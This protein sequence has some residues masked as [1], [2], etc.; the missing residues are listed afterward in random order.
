MSRRLALLIGTNNYE[1]FSL[2]A[3]GKPVSDVNGLAEVLADPNIGCF[4]VESLLLNEDHSQVRT[5]VERFFKSKRSDDLLLLYFAGHGVLDEQGRL[6]LA[7]TN[8]QRSLLK[9]T[10]IPA[11]FVAGE[12]QESDSKS[13]LLILDCCHSGAF[14]RGARVAVGAPVHTA[15][16]FGNTKKGFG[17]IV[18][19]ATDATQYAL[20]SSAP[21][22]ADTSPYSLFTR[23]LIEGLRTGSADLDVDGEVTHDELFEYVRNNVISGSKYQNP[24]MWMYEYEGKLTLA[25]APKTKAA[26]Q[27]EQELSAIVESMVDERAKDILL[28][29]DDPD[30]GVRA[31]AVSAIGDLNVEDERVLDLLR[32]VMRMDSAAAVQVA[33]RNSL[34]ALGCATELGMVRIPAGPFLMGTSV[35][36][37]EYLNR[38]YAM[39]TGWCGS[40]MPQ[41][42]I[43]LPEFFIDRTPVTNHQFSEFVKATGH[44][45][46]AEVLGSGWVKVGRMT[47]LYPLRGAN[48]AHPSGPGSS[49]MNIPDHPVVLLSWHDTQAYAEW[50][51]KQLPTEA[52]WEKAA[53]GSDGRIWPWGND[54][55]EGRCNS[56][57]YHA[58][59]SLLNND[60][61]NYWW[62][63]FDQASYGPPTTSVEAFPQGDSPY[64]VRDCVGNVCE[65]TGDWYKPY[66]GTSFTS[67]VFG[68]QLHV[69][70]GGAWHHNLSLVRVASR[71]YAH[72]S[73]RTV[74][75]GFRCVVRIGP[76]S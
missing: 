39:A 48:W 38:R 33:A 76:G 32:R 70:R 12:M 22:G 15:D 52:Q 37:Q 50:A 54:W 62:A 8:T 25:K 2:S 51:G 66:P 75:D 57:S 49:W 20:E 31:T 45:T 43:D 59:R 34:L 24:R 18:M 1:D 17:R 65:R 42:Q 55:E 3:L 53:R 5:A 61:Y 7:V 35:E 72:P 21:G 40:E 69:L 74:H 11:A 58:T 23:Y 19:T 64:G 29:F 9:S 41:H 26:A 4:E 71:D 67:E 28:R 14:V 46:T 68:D 13:Q 10:A 6:Y 44:Q 60:E 30:A 56:A 47:D 27:P 36:Q 73:Y 16:V 63:T